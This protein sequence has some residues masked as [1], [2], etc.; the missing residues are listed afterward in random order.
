MA[1]FWG[2]CFSF[3]CRT[4]LFVRFEPRVRVLD[5]VAQAKEPGLPQAHRATHQVKQVFAFPLDLKDKSA[6]LGGRLHDNK[7]APVRPSLTMRRKSCSFQIF[8]CVSRMR[9][10]QRDGNAKVSHHDIATRVLRICPF[11]FQHGENVFRAP[12]SEETVRR[13]TSQLNSISASM[14]MTLTLNVL[15]CFFF[16]PKM[17]ILP[18]S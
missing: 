10:E 11:V 18:R 12:C 13:P 16:K 15:G 4:H 5:G 17:D 7:R 2:V 14:V 9:K 3:L 1:A 8:F 6:T